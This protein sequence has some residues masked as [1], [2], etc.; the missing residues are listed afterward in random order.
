VVNPAQKKTLWVNEDDGIPGAIEAPC[1]DESRQS[2]SKQ[3]ED[4]KSA[5]QDWK[6]H[7]SH[8]KGGDWPPM[9]VFCLLIL[10]YVSEAKNIL[11]GLLLVKF[12]K[13]TSKRV[14]SFGNALKGDFD[15]LPQ[16][17]ITL[18]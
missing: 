9:Q 1:L 15:H 3:A 4:Y 18:I 6:V 17:E 16:R 14:G 7:A 8:D 12:K 10:A 13:E 5:D 11:M 2:S